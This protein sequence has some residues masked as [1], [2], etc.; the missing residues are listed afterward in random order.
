MMNEKT[1][2]MEYGTKKPETETKEEKTKVEE[3]KV[4]VTYMGMVMSYDEFRAL[5]E[6]EK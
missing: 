1:K 3:E 5:K 4:Y 6:S 2:E